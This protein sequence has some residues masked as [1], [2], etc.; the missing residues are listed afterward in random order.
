METES[1]KDENF[2]YLKGDVISKIHDIDFNSED[3]YIKI[4]FSTI[5]NKTKYIFVTPLTS[6]REWIMNKLS[7]EKKPANIFL[8]YLVSFFDSSEEVDDSHER[9]DEIIDDTNEVIPDQDIPSNATNRMIGANHTMD[10]EKIFKRS[11]PKSVRNYS[12][13]L[14]L[15]TV[16]W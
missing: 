12:G 8:D 4:E 13:N 16:V 3:N 14:G 1:E 2:I 9:I 15:G 7:Q 11:M 10:L 5:Y 6:F